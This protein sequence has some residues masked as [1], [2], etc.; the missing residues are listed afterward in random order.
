MA[1]AAKTHMKTRLEEPVRHEIYGEGHK[2][3]K[4]D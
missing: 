1:R 3:D 4:S 2:S